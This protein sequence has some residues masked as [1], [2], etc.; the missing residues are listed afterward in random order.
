[1]GRRWLSP[2]NDN[3]SCWWTTT[4]IVGRQPAAPSRHPNHSA[5]HPHI[6]RALTPM[7]NF[8]DTS[9]VVALHSQREPLA[10]LARGQVPWAILAATTSNLLSRKRGKKPSDNHPSRHQRWTTSGR[11]TR[12]SVRW[13]ASRRCWP[14]DEMVADAGV[15]LGVFAAGFPDVRKHVGSVS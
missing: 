15:S 14:E 6:T 10:G 9:M 1:M 2:T 4:S 7:F 13:S 11:L 3:Y 8:G 12:V 5:S